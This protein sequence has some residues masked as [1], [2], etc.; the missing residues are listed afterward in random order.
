MTG[1]VYDNLLMANPAA[2]Y[3]QLAEACRVAEIHEAIERLPKVSDGD[4]RARR[5]RGSP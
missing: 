5:W 3:E 1:T 4:R 2:S